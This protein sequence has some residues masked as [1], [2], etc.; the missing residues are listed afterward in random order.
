M[1][2]VNGGST[3][4][5]ASAGIT[6]AYGQAIAID[7]SAPLTMYAGT[8]KGLFKTMDGGI[9][10]TLSIS[11]LT[12]LNI[13]AVNV[14]P[15]TPTTVYAATMGGVFKSVDGGANWS[16]RN[17]G[18]VGTNIAAMTRDTSGTTNNWYV[19]TG[20]SLY[21]STNGVESW[22][23]VK[24]LNAGTTRAVAIRW[25]YGYAGTQ[26]QGVFVWLVHTLYLPLLA[27]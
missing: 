17:T 18:L 24:H 6:T 1:Q 14:E 8:D 26:T 19:T 22:T 4:I 21:V 3:W 27:H 25:P 12:N 7:A 13:V 11:G 9:S 10:W 23:L 16:A 5:T 15:L 20:G 2:S